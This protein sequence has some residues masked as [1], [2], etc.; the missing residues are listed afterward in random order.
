MT[1]SQFNMKKTH[2]FCGTG[3]L[4]YCTRTVP[5]MVNLIAQFK[6]GPRDRPKVT[7][8]NFVLQELEAISRDEKYNEA[9]RLGLIPL[10]LQHDGVVI[11]KTNRWDENSLKQILQSKSSAALGYNQPLDVKKM[12]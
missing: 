12:P 11:G 5:E 4:I 7:T 2:Q 8:K 10:S 1:Y 3:K 6:N 9:I